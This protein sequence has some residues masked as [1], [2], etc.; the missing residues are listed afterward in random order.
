MKE[1]KCKKESLQASK[2]YFLLFLLLGITLSIFTI[3]S[4]YYLFCDL[5]YFIIYF[6]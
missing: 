1:L 2:I 4:L 6:F 3:Y 5:L